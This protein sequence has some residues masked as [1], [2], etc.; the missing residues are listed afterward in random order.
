[1]FSALGKQAAVI[2]SCRKYRD[3]TDSVF[4]TYSI[5]DDCLP[6]LSNPALD[7]FLLCQS[8]NCT[9]M[10]MEYT[11]LFTSVLNIRIL[12]LVEKDGIFHTILR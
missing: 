12:F 2:K 8:I 5:G 6:G 1:M 9:D 11:T 10:S 3:V 4:H 7:I